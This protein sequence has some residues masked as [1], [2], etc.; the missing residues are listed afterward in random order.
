V[1]IYIGFET[2]KVKCTQYGICSQV[3]FNYARAMFF[4]FSGGA[5]NCFRAGAKISLEGCPCPNLTPPIVRR[6]GL[7][8]CRP[9]GWEV[10]PTPGALTHTKITWAFSPSAT[11]VPGVTPGS[12]LYPWCFGHP[13]WRGARQGMRVETSFCCGLLGYLFM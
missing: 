2:L 10:F 5:S 8:V 11:Q 7:N 1:H 4:S 9:C 13:L 3:V 12:P 6:G